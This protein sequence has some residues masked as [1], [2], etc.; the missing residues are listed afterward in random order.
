MKPINL[1]LHLFSPSYEKHED[2]PPIAHWLLL[3]VVG[4]LCWIACGDIASRVLEMMR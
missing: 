4:V 3:A 1:I 2:V